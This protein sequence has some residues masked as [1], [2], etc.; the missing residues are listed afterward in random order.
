MDNINDLNLDNF[1]NELDEFFIEMQHSAKR[2][3]MLIDF[4]NIDLEYDGKE[5]TL[6]EPVLKKDLGSIKNI[7]LRNK[8]NNK[9][10]MF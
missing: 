4:N 3:K 2:L 8:N 7:D 6:E 10:K 9:N 5:I 1:Y